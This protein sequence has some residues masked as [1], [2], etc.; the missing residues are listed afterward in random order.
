[1][2]LKNLAPHVQELVE[3][4]I[5]NTPF[6]AP[7]CAVS[8]RILFPIMWELELR[9]YWAQ[10]FSDHVRSGSLAPPVGY[11]RLFDHLFETDVQKLEAM[12]SKAFGDALGLV[13]IMHAATNEQVATEVPNLDSEAEEAEGKDQEGSWINR[14]LLKALGEKIGLLGVGAFGVAFLIFI[15][16]ATGVVTAEQVI[17]FAKV[18]FAK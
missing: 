18:L 5:E 9:Q 4:A 10:H 16:L 7:E 12:A 6:K 11:D 3:A 8:T 2:Q 1:M 17:E 15:T 14:I 13:C